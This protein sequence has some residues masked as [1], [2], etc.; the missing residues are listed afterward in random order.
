MITHVYVNF[1]S[2]EI[3]DTIKQ[4]DYY[5]NTFGGNALACAV[6]SAALDVS[7]IQ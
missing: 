3:A 6:A 2:I 7:V 4:V 5:Y 1:C